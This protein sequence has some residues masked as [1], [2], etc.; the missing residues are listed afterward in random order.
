[1][2]YDPLYDKITEKELNQGLRNKIEE[3]N[4]H[5]VNTLMHITEEER[6]RWNETSAIGTATIEKSGLMSSSMVKKLNSITEGANNYIHPE[7]GVS[8]GTYLL[9]TVDKYGHI[10]KGENPEM[11]DITVTNAN[12]LGSYTA[13]S[14]A[15]IISPT[16]AGRPTAPTVSNET[17]GDNIATTKYVNNILNVALG[18]NA[19]IHPESGVTTAGLPSGFEFKSAVANY[20]AIATTYPSPKKGWV[21]QTSDNSNYYYYNGTAWTETSTQDLKDMW[22]ESY[23]IVE[24]NRY[25]HVVS[26]VPLKA[27]ADVIY[28]IGYIWI[29]TS[30]VNPGTVVGG[31]WEAIGQGRC[32]IGA[33]GGYTAG[34]T[35]G[36]ATHKLTVAE[37]PAHT[38]T[39]G[40]MNI[41][42]TGPKFNAEIWTPSDTTDHNDGAIL[43]G[44]SYGETKL[45]GTNED[46]RAATY[47]WNFDASLGWTGETS[48]VGGNQ[49]HNNMQPYLVVYMWARIA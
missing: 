34:D 24:V 44:K 31:T 49:A 11:L 9:T 38:H 21:V 47:G 6:N 48:S 17:I 35:G 18:D 36:E 15:K 19:Y 30:S 2:A 16:F 1:M 32:L 5:I 23:S 29:S 27:L 13:D 46:N 42:G 28:P 39:R 4:N 3:S 33:G 26:G 37:T 14:F 22:T 8:A 45:T 25:G 10:T 41:T 20:T 40:T 43:K 7:S 12:K